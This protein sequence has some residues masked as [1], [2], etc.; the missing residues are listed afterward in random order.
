MAPSLTDVDLS[1]DILTDLDFRVELP[2]QHH[3][4]KSHH[5]PTDGP[6]K[7]ILTFK[8]PGCNRTGS[9]H[10][11]EAGKAN[12]SD[13]LRTIGDS[14]CGYTGPSSKWQL[15]FEPIPEAS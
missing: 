10:L 9:I 3:Q 1:L 12:L 4:H 15:T 5:G 13:S 2:C 7:Y 8:C 11:C 14:S 6:A